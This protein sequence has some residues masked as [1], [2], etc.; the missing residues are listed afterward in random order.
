MLRDNMSKTAQRRSMDGAE[1]K[2]LNAIFVPMRILSAHYDLPKR[3]PLSDSA[4]GETM[5]GRGRP[6]GRLCLVSLVDTATSFS[7]SFKLG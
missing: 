7:G 3:G 5:T 2:P 4:S 1:S 6:Q